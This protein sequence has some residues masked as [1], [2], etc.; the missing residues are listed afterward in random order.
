MR[1]LTLEGAMTETPVGVLVGRSDR[2]ER[3]NRRV[4]RGV[5]AIVLGVVAVLLMGQTLPK[6]PTI[7]AQKLV[8]KDKRGKIR[9]VLGE[10][11]DDEPVGLLVFDANQRIRAKLGLQEDGS[12]TLA[13]ADD[14]GVDRVI[15]HPGPGLRVLGGG[16]GV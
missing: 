1:R 8:L 12:P 3:Q 14:R 6:S 10:F 4:K 9:A 7:E 13:L 5:T 2:L 11:S 15:L 16:P